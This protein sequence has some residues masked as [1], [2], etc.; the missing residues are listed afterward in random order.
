MSILEKENGLLRR[1]TAVGIPDETLKELIAR[2]QPLTALQHLMQPQFKISHSYFIPADQTPIL[3]ADVHYVYSTYEVQSEVPKGNAWNPDDFLIF[4]IEDSKGEILGL[5]SVDD[6]SDGLRPDLATIDSIEAFS[7][8]AALVLAQNKL[9]SGL[10][11]RVATLDSGLQRQQKLLDVTQNDLPVLLRKDLEATISLHNLDQRAQ[12]VRAG[13]AITE[14]VSRQ[15]DSSSALLALG[16]ET[17]TQLGMTAA[18][19]AE[20]SADGPRLLHTLGSVPRTTNVDAL[21]GQRN[22]LRTCMQTGEAILVSSMDDSEEWRDSPLLTSLRVKSF[23]CLP[24]YIQ[25]KPVAAMLALSPETMPSFTAEDRQVYFQI[26]RQSSVIL[27]NISLLNETRRRLQ[28]VNLLLDFSRRLTGL[29]SDEI[30]K[31]LLN[32]AMHVIPSAH[33]GT[34]LVWNQQAGLLLPLAV[35]G[36]ADNETMGRIQYRS[37]EALPGA[38]YAEKRIRRV[39]EVNFARD[40][41]LI[42]ENITLYRQAVGGRMP[43]SCIH[44]PILTGEQ[45]LGV[46]TLDNFNTQG[47]FKSDDETLLISLTQQVALSFENVRLMQAMRERAGQLQALN[48]VATSLTS[49]LRSDQLVGSLLDNLTPILP[50]DSAAFWFREGD[51]LT[52]VATRGYPDTEDPLGASVGVTENALFDKMSQTGQAI[53]IGDV[54]EDARFPRVEAPRLSWLGIPLVSKGVL[55]GVLALEKWQAYYYAPEQ[56]QVGLTFAS[57]AAV[58]LENARLYEDSLNRAEE[59]DERSQRLALLNRF[60]SSLSGLLDIDQILQLA[61]EELL[62]AVGAERVSVVTFENNQA[63]WKTTVPRMKINLPR[64]LP[65]A[66]IFVHLRESLGVFNTD[67]AHNEGDVVPLKDMLGEETTAL[68]V[69]SIPS[70]QNLAGLLFAQSTGAAHFSPVEIELARTIVN[71]VSISLDNARLYQSNL[72]TANRLN[73]LHETSSEVSSHSEADEIYLS[74]HKAAEKLMRVDSIAI[75]LLVEQSGEIEGVYLVEGKMRSLPIRVSKERGLN[76]EVIRTG[77]SILL[78]DRAKIQAAGGRG[79]GKSEDGQSM[80]LVPMMAGGKVRGVL[81]VQ[82]SEPG[83]YSNEDQQILGTLANQA[84]VGIQNEQLLTETRRLTQELDGR[85]TERTSQLE[86]DQHHT[87]TLL[88]IL[89]EVS[90]SLDLDRALNRT[91]SL[92]NNTIGAEQG[93]I[94]LLHPE[95]NLLHFQ[96]G[97]GYVS[98]RSDIA[99]RNLTLKIGEGLAGWVVRNR[100]PALVGDLHADPRWLKSSEGIDHRSCIAIPMI[101]GDDVIGV[102]LVFHRAVN[103]FNPD[104][105]NLVKAVAAQV[106]VAINNA[107]L[108]ELIRDQADRLGVMLRKEQ[109]DASRSQAILAAVADGVLVTG[110]NNQI[111]FINP[112]IERIL[113]VEK[114]KLLGSPLDSFAGLFGK[115]SGAWMTT[116]RRWSEEPS[117]YQAGDTYAEQ[118]ELEDGRIALVHLAPVIMENEFLGTV[119][120]FSDITQQ[121]E[122]DK[123]KSEF[124]S[125]VS[126]ELRTPMTSIKGY[127]DLLQM[128]AA[129]ALNDNQEHFVDIVSNNINRLNM[130]LDEL[131][132]ISRFEAGHVIITPAAVDLV[133]LAEEAVIKIKQRSEK[134]NKPMTIKLAIEEDLPQIIG[135]AQ[136]VRTILNH[137]LDNAYNYTPENGVISVQIISGEQDDVQV[138]IKDN[139]IGIPT[140]N[141][142]QVFERFWRGDDERVL[143]TPGTGLGLPIVRQLVEMHKGKIW[144]KSL[145]V[146]GEGSVFSFTLPKHVARDRKADMR[147]A[148]LYGEGEDMFIPPKDPPRDMGTPGASSS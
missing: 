88:K 126:H 125:T 10:R 3:P 81:S 122:V 16:R 123:M 41:V 79:F 120:I 134:E 53:S 103:Y 54:R 14:Q 144:L 135:D 27:Q 49:S 72:Q 40:Y 21:F 50:F 22:P 60:S 83:A 100:Q 136:H 108:Y 30:L 84:I 74:V 86:H 89:T 113:H 73:L 142:E 65:E 58:A 63:I 8:Q 80:I 33:A 98:E 5:I 114:S 129:G 105:Q 70:G 69:I 45:C 20:N 102:L 39:D 64:L 36:Y 112:S 93:T 19:V 29:D 38:A 24:V 6:P 141:Q 48:D 146:P 128:G 124:V 121:V 148:R 96:A 147:T 68:M 92:L 143:A 78:N 109:E 130:L 110:A 104:M 67:D 31:T 138:D 133:H 44:V 132:D 28:E 87:E 57:Q 77:Q 56:I 99:S 2:K 37:G 61:A 91:L 55:A 23:I 139:G 62:K 66:P 42:P 11:D 7:V 94:M 32:S 26:A 59:L 47:A 106:A 97:Y 101:V 140:A 119:S 51:Q 137:L 12:R 82:S 118:L 127:V 76:G 75:G 25:E 117:I 131:L 111:S 43:V 9:I 13:L 90:S 18:M 107:H 15:L 95:D 17:L 4:P 35:S 115:S 34:V 1:I 52:V 71:Q 116:I 85:V 145:G 46:L